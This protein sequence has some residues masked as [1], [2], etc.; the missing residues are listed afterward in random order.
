MFLCK[1]GNSALNLL[2]LFKLL[3]LAGWLRSSQAADSTIVTGLQTRMDQFVSVCTFY[4]KVDP[5]RWKP[6]VD[7]WRFW[8]CAEKSDLSFLAGND[9]SPSTSTSELGTGCGYDSSDT[10]ETVRSSFELGLM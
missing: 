9:Y 2:P 5:L 4:G 3:W 10:K 6:L 1:K 7:L 8:P